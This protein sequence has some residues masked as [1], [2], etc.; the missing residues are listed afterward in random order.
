M[1]KIFLKLEASNF[2]EIFTIFELWTITENIWQYA[3]DCNFVKM[4]NKIV[5]NGDKGV[6]FERFNT[7]R[8]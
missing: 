2:I 6:S 7:K 1:F 5:E 3:S 8:N 4:E